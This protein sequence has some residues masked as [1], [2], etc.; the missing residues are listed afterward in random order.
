MATNPYFKSFEGGVATEQALYEDLVIESI[1]MYGFEAQYL[2]RH[3]LEEDDLLNEEVLSKFDKAY[4]LEM[5]ITDVDGFE[6]EDF[7]SKFGLQITDQCTLV[8]SVKRWEEVVGEGDPY[9]VA[10]PYKVVEPYRPREGDLIYIPFSGNLFE[11]R[12][13]ED[14]VPFFQLNNVPVYGLRCEMF[15]YENQA[16]DTGVDVIDE[17]EH[18]VAPSVNAKITVLSGTFV[19]TEKLTLTTPSGITILAELAGS[20]ETASGTVVSLTNITYP[21]GG[22]VSLTAG[23]SVLGDTSGAKGIV[24]N[25]IGIDDPFHYLQTNDQFQDNAEFEQEKIDIIDFTETNPFGDL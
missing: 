1:Q 11:I 22:F 8:V 24:G 10:D 23:T 3:I 12:F 2:P 14:Q 19:S 13:V 9:A 20:I 6:G 4:E 25:V 21:A 5:Y 16:F 17:I 18:N 15:K 7:L